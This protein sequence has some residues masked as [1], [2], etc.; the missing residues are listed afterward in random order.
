MMRQRSKAIQLLRIPEHF[1]WNATKIAQLPLKERLEKCPAFL[2]AWVAKVAEHLSPTTIWVFGSRARGD[3]GTYS[4]YDL[5]IRLSPETS[6]D[7]AAFDKWREED[8]GTL[9]SIDL[10]LFDEATEIL[11]KEILHSGIVLYEKQKN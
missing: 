10:V 3:H 9:L 7:W 8:L 11:Q 6:S 1:R 5:A 2:R 4:D